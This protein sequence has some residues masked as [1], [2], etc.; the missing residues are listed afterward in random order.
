GACLGGRP[1]PVGTACG[2]FDPCVAVC[3]AAG[4]CNP[5]ATPP[6]NCS[7]SKACHSTCT[8]D[9]KACRGACPAPGAAR[10]PGR[11]ARATRS[12]CAAPD[13]RIRTLAYVTSECAT[14]SDSVRQTLFVRRGNCDPVAILNTDQPGRGCPTNDRWGGFMLPQGPMQRLGVSPDGST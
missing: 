6:A 1:A 2:G 12:T 14:S 10:R 8:E 3:D 13:A 4:Q 7:W 9:L 5:T 11:A